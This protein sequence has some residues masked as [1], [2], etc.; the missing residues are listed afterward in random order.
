MSVKRKTYSADFKAKLVLEVLEGERTV[1]EIASKYEV[2]P[3]SLKNWKKQFLENMSLAFDKSAVVKEYKEEI[4][5][6]QKNNDNLAKKVG[7]LTIE[8]DFLEGKLVSLVSS[9]ER[10]TLIDTEHTF[11]INKQCQLL[12]VSKSSLYY[13][14]I[15]PFSN[16]SDLKLLDSIN[17]IYSDF[18]SYGYRRIHAQLQ[19]DGYNIGKKFV[20]KA[21]RYMGIEALYPKPKTTIAN[22]EHYKYE[23]L[24]KEFRNYAG[25]VVIE[26]TNQVWSTDITYIKLEKGFVYLAAIIDWHSKKIL[27]WKLSNT[28]DVS[29]TTSVLKEAL[30]LYPKPEIFN[31]DQGSQ[32][33]S[34][35]HTG[36]LKRHNIK[37]SMDGKGRA[38]DNICIERFWRSIKYEEIYLNEYK[39]IK[40]LYR[41]IEKYMDS[42]NMRRLHSAIDYKTPNEVYYQAVNNLGSKGAKLL[43]QVS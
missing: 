39:N 26:N 41:S 24:L 36:I 10:K 15:K 20:K 43:Q 13:Q 29:L 18:P 1:N 4:E 12:N 2:L 14:P 7:N 37:I 22:K 34:K 6:L 23:Y 19:K 42:Y 35:A 21:M 31:T 27:S 9:K 40:Q 11:S 30:A 32:Y 8:K 28:M 3:I 25:Q 16:N 33:T 17:N 38:T 5:I